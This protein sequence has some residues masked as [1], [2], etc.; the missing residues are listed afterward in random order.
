MDKISVVVPTL[1]KN[2]RVLNR[3]LGLL[4]R[5]DAVFEIIIIN[6]AKKPFIPYAKIRN[7]KKLRIHNQKENLYVNKSWNLGVSLC[8]KDKFFITNDDIMFCENFCT[9]VLETGILDKKDTGLAGLATWEIDSFDTDTKNI[10]IPD[11]AGE[12]YVIEM[13]NYMRTGDWGS[14][15]FGKKE[16]YYKIPK[17]LKVIY[18]DNYLLYKNIENNKKN[19]QICGV[20]YNHIHSLSSSSPCMREAVASDIHTYE[21]FMPDEFRSD[22]V[23]V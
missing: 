11:S 22:L 14:G 6:N 20:K 19:Y 15:F 8:K 7:N 10:D 3:L 9:K 23:M 4:I 1:Q 2:K 12:L 16:N 18:G 21:Q 5:D 13:Q 17:E